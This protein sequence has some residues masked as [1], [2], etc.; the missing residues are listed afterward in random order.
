MRSL[1]VLFVIIV[2]SSTALF[3]QPGTGIRWSRDGQ[4]VLK[5]STEGIMTAPLSGAATTIKVPAAQYTPAGTTKPLPIKDFYF[6]ADEKKLLIYTNAKKVWRYETR[7]DYW[8]LDLTT[9]KLQQ[10]GKDKPAASLMFAK[11]SPD[12][13]KV[14]Y[15]SGHNIYVEDLNTGTIQAMTRDGSRRLING[16]FDWV[17]EEEF[18]CRDGFRWSPD[19]NNI[20]YWQIDATGIR[21]FL[22]INNTDSIYSFTTPVEYPVAGENPSACRIGVVDIHTA[23]TT[24]MQVPGDQQQHYIP[25]MEWV[26]GKKELIIQQ[27]NR[28]QNESKIMVCQATNGKAHTLY[29]EKDTAWI[30]V[31]SRWDDNN[32]EGWDF[33][34][35]GKAFIWVS[36]QDGWR[37]LYNIPLDKGK[38]TLLTPGNYDVI[39]IAKVDEANHVIYFLASP[40]NATQQYL[41]QVPLSGGKAVR[42]TPANE[43]GTHSYGISPSGS[44]AIHEFSNAYTYPVVENIQLPAHTSS[45]NT[46]AQALK[47]A[48]AKP[49]KVEYFQVT[50]VDGVTMDGWMSKPANF[51]PAKKYPVVFYVYG[52]PAGAT[53]LDAI[54][55]G[56]NYLY[57]GDMA[58]DGYIYISMDNR[59]TPLPKGR[60]WRKCVYRKVGVINTR[61]QAMGALALMRKYSFID[62]SRTAVWG[63][64]GGGSMTLNLLFQYPDIYKTG[65][66]IAAVGNQLTYDN[67]YQERYMGLPQ[68]NRED[69]V[70][71]SPITYARNLKGNLL[72]IHGTGDD[73]VH[74]Q[75]AEMLL[76]ELIKYNKQ[77]QFM[78]YPNRTHNISEGEGTFEHLST[79]YTNYLRTHCEP[80]GR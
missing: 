59:G 10:L 23:K 6:S 5:S 79:L 42:I 56:R 80:G 66:A 14:A 38:A 77:I 31:K 1:T 20:A 15:V 34:G 17:Y 69:F 68:E 72:Y 19:G 13:N 2:I 73:N 61:D 64:S 25:R 21:D 24:W 9:G 52:E 43:P 44:W 71:G 32:I 47:E 27:L 67:I 50:T 75:N 8:V 55:A 65:I 22:M 30:D 16:T 74:Y 12:G 35:N 57:D 70:K 3:A 39:N 49:N 58:A 62:S 54:G 41:Y 78:A 53:T 48:A 18:G 28:K 4:S 46:V 37:H 26:P 29:E 45:S 7:G 40:E 60:Y 76:N 33:T 11:L 36:E 51:N 63:W